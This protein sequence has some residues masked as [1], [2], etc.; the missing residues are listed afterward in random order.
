MRDVTSLG[1]AT[2]VILI[3]MIAAGYF[4]LQKEYTLLA[5]ILVAT[6]GGGILDLQL[7]E[8]FGRVRPSIIPRLVEVKSYG[9][10]SGHSMMSTIVY[11]SLASLMIR[12]QGHRRY[13]IYVLSVAFFLT[14]VIGS[15]RVYLGV[16]YPSDVIA[17][18]F[19]GVVWASL[20]WYVS[21]RYYRKKSDNR[22]QG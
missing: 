2:V 22:S 6:I 20:C 4:W 17:G 13:K 9:F 14:F 8:V 16:H 19:M 10:P 18:W 3:T 5:L 12:V 21:W 15:S 1:G 7:K 11:F